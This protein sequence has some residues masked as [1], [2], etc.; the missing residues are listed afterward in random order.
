ML[1][2]NVELS[3]MNLDHNIN[4]FRKLIHK[5]NP[6]NK[7]CAVVKSNAYGHGLTEIVTLCLESKVDLFGVNSLEEAHLIRKIH[8][9]IPVLIMGD[10]PNLFQRPKE[11][12]DENYW[13]MVSRFNEWKFLSEQSI[14]PKIHLKIDTGMGRL[15]TS[16]GIL[17]TIINQAREINLPLDGVA[18]H[19]ASTED[20]TE[21]SY[22]KMQLE[23]FNNHIAKLEELGYVNLIQHC[24]A[25]ASALLF[26]EARMDMVRVGISLYGLWPSI[27][28][29]LSM[30][31]L[32]RPEAELRPV[33]TWKTKIQHIQDLPTGSF[34]G[35]GSTYKTTSPT[36]V[37]VVPIGYYEGLDR[38]HSNNGYMLVMGERAKI[39]GRVCMN[40]TMIDL[41]HIKDVKIGDEVIIMGRSQNEIITADDLSQWA[42]TINYETVTKILPLFPRAITD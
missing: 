27:E 29:K 37:G 9:T 4:V 11:V 28:T 5:S 19:F 31:L 26:D 40:M 36:K 38:K 17:K 42:H 23:L 14:R 13:I 22:S 25:S 20:F 7:F 10:I 24:A 30:N 8:P 1:S 32:K 6:N 16:G 33:L 15:G 21:H 35:Y 2:A 41:T 3:R 18:T 39:L 12:Q 34:I